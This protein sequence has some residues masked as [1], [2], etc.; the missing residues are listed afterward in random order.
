MNLVDEN[1]ST[2]NSALDIL[3]KDIFLMCMAKI[4]FSSLTLPYFAC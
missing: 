1:K 4:Y 2:D 3:L